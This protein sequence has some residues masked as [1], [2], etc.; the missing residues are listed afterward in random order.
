MIYGVLCIILLLFHLALKL[1]WYMT[2]VLLVYFLFMV[3]KHRRKYQKQ[4][5][6]EQRFLDAGI[7]MDALLYAFAKERK[8]EAALSD[9]EASLPEGSMKNVAQKALSH[10]RMTFD[11]TE[12]AKDSLAIVEAEY[13]CKRITDIHTFLLHVESYGGETKGPIRLFIDEKNHWE[14]RMRRAMEE[15]KHSFRDIVLSISASLMICGMVMYLPVMNVDI[16]QNWLIQCLTVIVI[17]LD[18]L[19]LLR[20]QTYL[21]ADWLRMDLFEEEGAEKKMREFKNYDEKKQKRFSFLLALPFLAISGILF[22]MR[23]EWMGLI[24]LCAAFVCAYQ[25]VIGRSL[26][27]RN[28][29]KII[30]CAFPNWLMDLVLLLQSENVQ[31]ALQK[32]ERHVPGVLR[33]ELQ[34]LNARLEI[35]PESSEPYHRFL[36]EFALP[37]V[38]SAMSMLYSLSIGNSSSADQQV[39]ELIAR[40][41]QMLEAAEKERLKNKTSGMYLLFL[42]PVLTASLKMV[43]DMAVFML[44]FLS[45]SVM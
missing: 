22:A 6:E 37:E 5:L 36:Q 32:S 10:M 35:E 24:G 41:Q 13:P 39:T 8:I 25:H 23:Q 9:V 20:A 17:F 38:S 12:V 27:T 30:R 26:G 28:L 14:K 45:S 4:K 43:I 19:I 40:N 29:K 18:D 42:A 44:T 11:E 34:M 16:S 21:T 2:G 3:P 15:R 7:Y 1:N 33:E 31:V